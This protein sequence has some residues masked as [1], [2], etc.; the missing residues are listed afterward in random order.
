MGPPGPLPITQPGQKGTQ[1][2]PGAPGLRGEKGLPGLD[3][4]P[5]LPGVFLEGLRR[6]RD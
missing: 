3:G 6:G 5:G 2:Q 1:G 4:P